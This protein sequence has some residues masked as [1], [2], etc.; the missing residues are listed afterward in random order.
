MGI[1]TNPRIKYNKKTLLEMFKYLKFL[2]KLME[3]MKSLNIIMPEVLRRS[4]KT[5]AVKKGMKLKN[6]ICYLIERDTQNE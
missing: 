6:Y 5:Q 4:A 2:N 1:Y 3:N